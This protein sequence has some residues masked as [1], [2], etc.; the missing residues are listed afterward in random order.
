M[1]K[2]VSQQALKAE[3]LREEKREEIGLTQ[4]STKYLRT[5]F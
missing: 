2:T 5:S 1:A 4:C 3:L